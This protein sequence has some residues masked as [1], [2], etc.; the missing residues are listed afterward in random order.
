M[1]RTAGI[2]IIRNDNKLLIAHPTGGRPDK[3]SIPKGRPENN[4]YFT[5]AAVREVFEECNIDLSK[6]KILHNLDPVK[7]EKKEKTLHPYV[8]F[9]RQNFIDLDE[10]ELKCNENVP[11]EMGGYPEM[12]DFKWV[13]IEEARKV[14]YKSQVKCLDRIQEL[15]DKIGSK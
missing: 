14:L 10:F 12:D 6:W 1:E 2:F 3:W 4:E 5:D 9:E 15:I 8:F 11:E 7:Y 13:T